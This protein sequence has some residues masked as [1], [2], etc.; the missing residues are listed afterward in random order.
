M[1]G[2]RVAIGRRRAKESIAG[3]AGRRPSGQGRRRLAQRATGRL[4]MEGQRLTGHLRVAWRALQQGSSRVRTAAGWFAAPALGFHFGGCQ[5]LFERQSLIWRRVAGTGRGA[6]STGV[7]RGWAGAGGLPKQQ[8]HE[9]RPRQPFPLT[10]KGGGCGR[11]GQASIHAAWVQLHSVTNRSSNANHSH[12]PLQS[13]ERRGT[14]PVRKTLKHRTDTAHPRSTG[15]YVK[16]SAG[17]A[18]LASPKP[19]PA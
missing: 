9:H 18:H 3:A 7:H 13:V 14:A 15:H 10:R 6:V 16:E 4:R 17:R 12:V 1:T 11:R 19:I 2:Q 5:G 8:H